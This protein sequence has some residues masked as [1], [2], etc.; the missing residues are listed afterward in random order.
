MD[1]KKGV[2]EMGYKIEEIE[3]IGPA[4]REKLSAAKIDSS[5]CRD[6]G[7]ANSI[8]VEGLKGFG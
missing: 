7:S 2:G 8:L 3:G 6:S 1:E 4:F 5:T